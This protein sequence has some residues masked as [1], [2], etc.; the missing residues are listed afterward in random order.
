[1]AAWRPPETIQTTSTVKIVDVT[2][3]TYVGD[4]PMRARVST[5]QSAFL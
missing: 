3:H 4:N 5:S 1:V 2:G